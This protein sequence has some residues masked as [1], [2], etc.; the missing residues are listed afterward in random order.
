MGQ[1]SLRRALS[2][3]ACVGL[4]SACPSA[5]GDGAG[6]VVVLV[7]NRASAT[8][9]VLDQAGKEVARIY[10]HAGM[11][12]VWLTAVTDASTAGTFAVHLKVRE[13]LLPKSDAPSRLLMGAAPGGAID[14]GGV[15][16]LF[17]DQTI[18][19]S[20]VQQL[21]P[22][23]VMGTV[24]AHEIGHLLLRDRGHSAEGLMRASWSGGDWQRASSG[25]LLLSQRESETMRATISSCQ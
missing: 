18:E 5:A 7:D 17:F 6:P 16:Y 21:P 9:E 13:G 2:V 24:V 25:F 12:I 14:C 8:P 11:R 4:V 19:F 20:R 15:A 3:I 23:L 10:R 1:P 22:A